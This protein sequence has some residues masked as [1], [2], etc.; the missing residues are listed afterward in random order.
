MGATDFNDLS[1][2]RDAVEAFNNAIREARYEHGHGGYSG[3][4]AEK[5]G[6]T[7]VPAIPRI[8]SAKLADMIAGDVEP[9]TQATKDA[10]RRFSD[11]YEDKWGPALCIELAGKELANAKLA[12]GLKGTRKKVFCFF[13]IASS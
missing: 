9:T 13:G 2:G 6:F 3:T 1:A 11:A 7:V 4:I 5:H 12:M 8:S 10:V